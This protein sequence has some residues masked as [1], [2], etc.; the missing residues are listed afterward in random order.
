MGRALAVL[1][2]SGGGEEGMRT[3]HDWHVPLRD[4]EADD[5]AFERFFCAARKE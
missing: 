4:D 1:W 3:L 5:S 2:A